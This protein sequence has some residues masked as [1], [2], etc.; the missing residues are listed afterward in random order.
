MSAIKIPVFRIGVQ[1]LSLSR[2][3]AE[4]NARHAGDGETD[5]RHQVHQ[6]FRDIRDEA[7][8]VQTRGN[9]S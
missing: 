8:R 4:I 9:T 6:S 7:T 1:K 5:I 2:V 3:P